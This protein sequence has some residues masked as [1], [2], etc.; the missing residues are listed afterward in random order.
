MGLGGIRRGSLLGKA[1]RVILAKS[2]RSLARYVGRSSSAVHKWLTREDWPFSL[3]P[4][5]KVARVKAWM[6]FALS[7][8]PAATSRRRA[9]AAA[10]GGGEFRPMGPAAK[11]KFQLAVEKYLALRRE[12]EIREGKFHDAIVCGQRRVQQITAAKTAFLE[13]PRI[14]IHDL[15]GQS[16][17]TLRLVE[18]VMTEH[19][20]KILESFANDG[21]PQA[22]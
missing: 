14:V 2:A 13:L 9:A 11:I 6:E 3:D 12:R 17:E 18:K 20:Y 10:A 22:S 1:K 21:R 16:P 8:D 19:V 7:P 15:A 5:W 4:P